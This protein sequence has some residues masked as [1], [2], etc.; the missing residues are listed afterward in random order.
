MASALLLT[1][2]ANGSR[3]L[4]CGLGQFQELF[5]WV[6]EIY[7][8]GA[9][10]RTRATS[11]PIFGLI[12]SLGRHKPRGDQ[13]LHPYFTFRIISLLS[14]HS[15]YLC[16]STLKSLTFFSHLCLS[17]NQSFFFLRLP[18]SLSTLS[19]LTHHSLTCTPLTLLF[20]TTPHGVSSTV[21]RGFDGVFQR[22][23]TQ[24]RPRASSC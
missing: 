4:I 16:R 17:L 1:S 21:S 2:C 22:P 18:L 14:P 6:S 7:N 19:L 8:C 12:V 11:L 5:F 23:Q 20:S 9:F 15:W 13:E 3:R 24:K 10:R